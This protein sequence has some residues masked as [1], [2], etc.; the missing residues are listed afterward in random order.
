MNTNGGLG[1]IPYFA[2]TSNPACLA[3]AT[4]L[5]PAA[6]ASLTNLGCYA[7]GGS[8][9]VPPPFGSV[10]TSG[11]D[12]F[13]GYPFQEWDL[14]VTKE[15]RLKERLTAQFRLEAF[16]ILNHV[17]FSNVFGGPGGDN[18]YTDPSAAAGFALPF[19]FRP[20]TPDITSS[21]PVLGQGG[22]RA[23]QVGLKL[24]F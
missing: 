14:S 8:V 20:Q 9:L 7:N 12:N 24:I 19:G 18:T 6:V 10:G 23:M 21:N 22:P 11:R 1:G 3:K 4:A 13:R 15:F 5:G 17:N 2:G 16:N